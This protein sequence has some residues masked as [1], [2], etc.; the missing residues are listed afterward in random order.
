M[1]REVQVRICERLAVKFPGPI[2]PTRNGRVAGRYC[3]A[4]IG[5]R[6]RHVLDADARKRLR[7]RPSPSISVEARDLSLVSGE[8]SPG[9][10]AGACGPPSRHCV[11]GRLNR[12]SLDDLASW[13]RLEDRWLFRER[14]DTPTRLRG[15]LLYDDE[16]GESWHHERA[17]LL[18]F[19][20][21]NFGHRL[22]DALDVLARDFVRMPLDDSLNEFRLRHSISHLYPLSLRN[23]SLRGTNP[24][25]SVRTMNY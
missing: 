22:D 11:F 3:V 13:L 2:R 6:A 17:G 25:L 24:P 4:D 15:G 18:E 9:Y 19:L 21:A 8:Q 1:N 20:V 10:D 16:L 23:S 5:G 7:R 12:S 14:I